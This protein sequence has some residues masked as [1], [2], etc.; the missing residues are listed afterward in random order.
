LES[1]YSNELYEAKDVKTRL[2][3]LEIAKEEERKRREAEEERQR[4][5]L[6]AIEAKRN[7]QIATARFN[8]QNAIASKNILNIN[9][10]L[11]EAIQ[12][13]AHIAEVE[14]ARAMLESLKKMEEIRSQLQAAIRVLQVKVESGINKL[15]LQPLVNAIEVSE[16]VVFCLVFLLLC[17]FGLFRWQTYLVILWN[18]LKRGRCF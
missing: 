5:A 2:V 10:S 15:D 16:K 11:Q 9:T 8:L 12:I 6:E 4:L 14:E 3:A 17:L 13:G 1:Y 7:A 18:Y